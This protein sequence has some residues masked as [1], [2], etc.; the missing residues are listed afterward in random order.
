MK[1]LIF[2]VETTGLPI[3]KFS[4]YTDVDNW[5]HIVQIAWCVYNEI[6]EPPSSRTCEI[7]RD[8][9]I[10]PN[11]YIIPIE[12][13]NIH[14]IDTE[15]ALLYGCPLSAVL[16]QFKTDLATVDYLVSH[17]MHFDFN[18]LMAASLRANI[19]LNASTIKKICTMSVSTP[20]CKL[21]PIKYN[22]YKYP[23]LSE[24][25]VKLFDT[26]PSGMHNAK[27]DVIACA[28]CFFALKNNYNLI[29]LLKPG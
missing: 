18:V 2:D 4:T 8:Y 3:N 11:N 19:D 21:L 23:K 16:T 7:L 10:K 27:N 22:T 1:Y 14:K 6:E 17:N 24:L 26:I 13:T 15:T 9:I 25:Y 5:P 20:F 12:S 28:R 29:K